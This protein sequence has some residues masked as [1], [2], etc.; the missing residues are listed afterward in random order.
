MNRQAR[1]EKIR[2]VLS[3]ATIGAARHV[4]RLIDGTAPSAG[5]T[6]LTNQD[7]AALALTA[8]HQAA[9]RAQQLSTG[10]QRLGVVVV[11]ARMEDTP[12]NRLSWEEQAAALRDQRAIEAVPKD[13]DAA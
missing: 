1:A 6:K 7:R 10:P 13:P 3:K 12:Q 9:D 8:G 2:D 11:H 4:R 5:D